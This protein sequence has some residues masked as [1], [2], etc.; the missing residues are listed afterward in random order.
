MKNWPPKNYTEIY[1]T[2]QDRLRKIAGNPDLTL[3]AKEYYK[4]RPVE[5]IE[6]WCITFDPRNAQKELPTTLP[7]VLFERQVQYIHFLESCRRD[8]E[9]GLA[10]KCR[11]MGATWL[12]CGYSVW[13]WLFVPGSSTGWGSRKETLVD[14]LGDPDSIFEKMRMLINALPRFFWPKGFNPDAHMSFMKIINPE[15]A[16]T[17]TGEG[18]DNIG[19]GGRKTIYFKDESAHYER[20]EKIEAALADNTRVQID[21]SSV[22]GPAT[23]FSRKRRSGVVWRRGEAHPVGT[24]RVFI[25][26]W[27]DHPLKTQ[28]WHDM[29]EAQAE[30]AGLGHLFAQEVDRDETAAIDGIVIPGAW[31]KAAIN[32]HRKLGFDDEGTLMSALDVADEGGDL[33]AYAS[34]KGAILKRLESWGKGDTAFTTGRAIHYMQQDGSSSLQYDSIGVGAGVK[35]EYNR[36]VRDAQEKFDEAKAKKKDV[37]PDSILSMALIGWNA[38]MSPLFK[39]RRFVLGDKQSPRNKDLFKNLK[40]QGW[41]QLRRRFEKTHEAVVGGKDYPAEELISL[42]SDLSKIH[43]LV[44]ELSQPTYS[45]NGRGQIV[46]NKSPDGA[47]SPNL[48]DVVMMNYWPV[49]IKRMMIGDR[50]A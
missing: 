33:N 20:P 46:I 47:K 17:I 26:D 44:L 13:L 21:I 16:A 15:N 8:E 31:V 10:E 22:N 7:F 25:F 1:L 36:R 19:R 18:G 40:A 29:R 34:R 35:G 41:W 12:S 42:P 45:L 50:A 2:R 38:G 3:G 30:A 32:A 14:K 27:S 11:D 5:F 23:V 43:E 4:T 49:T 48:A 39:N 24:I 6:H 37:K 9:N 28:E